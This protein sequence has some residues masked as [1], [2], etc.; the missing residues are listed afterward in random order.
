MDTDKDNIDTPGKLEKGFDKIISPFSLFINNEITGSVFLLVCTLFAIFIANSAWSDQYLSFIHTHIGVLIDDWQFEKSLKHWVNDGLMALFFFVLGLEIKREMLAGEL[1]DASLSVCVVASAIG[2]MALPALIYSGI[3]V[4]EYSLRGWGI[5]MATDA[6]FAVGILALLRKHIP[7]SLL[8]FL[9]A[10]A[11]IDDIGAV[12]VIA[13]FYTDTIQ[14]NY[15][16]WTGG[17]FVLLLFSNM[18]GIRRSIFYLILGVLLWLAMLNS[19]VHASISGILIAL[20]IPA[21]PAKNPA[22]LSRTIETITQKLDRRIDNVEGEEILSDNLQHKL[23]DKIRSYT[24][25][26]TT[27]LQR[28]S[29]IVERPVI[30]FVLP[31]FALVNA[32][33][34]LN[35][36][37]L[38]ELVYSKIMWGIVLGL[39]L[40]KCI[41]ISVLCWITLRLGIGRLPEGMNFYHVIGVSLLAGVGF[42]MSIFVADLGFNQ[43]PENLN[44]A[45]TAILLASLIAGISGYL[46]LRYIARRNTA[47]D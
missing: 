24:K 25:Q 7:A 33:I 30:L 45:K 13:I 39:V 41:G 29:H 23:I 11:I 3:N 47:Q 44:I 16:A 18:L 36:T 38:P 27:P 28:W 40:G 15:L 35:L 12:L 2:G 26:A 1:Q 42:T 8:T 32:G 20:T 31:I 19:G 5:P 37:I 22:K 10:L 9:I 34:I 17:L 21:R 4:G 6:A 46:W 43:H 14:L